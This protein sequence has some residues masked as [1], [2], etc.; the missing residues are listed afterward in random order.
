M[1]A[2]SRLLARVD[3]A[4][5][6]CVAPECGRATRAVG[7]CDTHYR[8]AR[9]G[10]DPY[11]IR[12]TPGRSLPDRFWEKVDRGDRDQCWTW[13]GAKSVL[14]YG[15]LKIDGRMV[16]AHRIAFE[17][18]RGPIP[19]GLCL[20]HL[21]R[22]PSCV[23]P[24]HLEPVTIRENNLRGVGV[25]AINARKTHCIRGHEFSPE[26]TFARRNGGRGCRA[27]KAI[28]DERF[29]ASSL[30]QLAEERER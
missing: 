29:R 20:D 4:A 11:P 27:C 16:K 25:A 30:R 5:G 23:N 26:N 10:V 14:G 21:C 7:M 24:S 22:T 13:L 18:E 1:D 28:R 3:E 9:R 2:L 15:H 12:R 17:I 6:T 19:D 8:Q